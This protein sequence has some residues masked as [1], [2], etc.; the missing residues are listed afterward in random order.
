MGGTRLYRIGQ[1]LITPELQGEMDAMLQPGDVML[2]RK[3]W[4]LS[5]VGLPGFW[6]HAILYLGDPQ[7][8]ITYFD[9]PAVQHYVKIQTGE[10][11]TFDAYMAKLY[12]QKWLCYKAGTGSFPYQTMEAIKYGVVL[13]PLTE[14]C[15]DYMAA[16]RPRLDKVAKAQAIIEAFRHLDKPYDFDFDFSTD[17]ALVCTEL[18]WRSYRPDINKRGLKLEPIELAGRKTLPANK[19]AALYVREHENHDRQFDFVFFVDA[20]EAEERAFL[21]DE[22]TF[23]ESVSRPKWSFALE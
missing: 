12:P 15:G 10:D 21:A 3:N 5:N 13:H 23:L 19:I 16:I 22:N 18:V 17:H 7:K 8:M 4:Y 20:L 9:D 1:Y 2:S 14:A 6:P 11:L